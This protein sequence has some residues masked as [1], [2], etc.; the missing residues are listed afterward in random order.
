MK[1]WLGLLN[2]VFDFIHRRADDDGRKAEPSVSDAINMRP[3]RDKIL[4]M[5][6]Y[7]SFRRNLLFNC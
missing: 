1:M 3:T 7:Y 6:V 4:G 2:N 5:K